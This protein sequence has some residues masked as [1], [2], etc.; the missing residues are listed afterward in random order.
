MQKNNMLNEEKRER[1]RK[2]KNKGEACGVRTRGK[3][4]DPGR[5]SAISIGLAIYM[6]AHIPNVHVVLHLFLSPSCFKK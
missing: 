5:P 2:G 6:Y 3:L 1:K 4:G